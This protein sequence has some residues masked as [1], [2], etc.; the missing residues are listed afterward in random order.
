M[1]K[2]LALVASLLSC[3]R[4]LAVPTGADEPLTVT[5]VASG[6]GSVD[7]AS[8]T[9]AYGGTVSFTATAEAGKELYAQVSDVQKQGFRY[10]IEIEVYLHD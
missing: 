6:G 10:L 9:V 4:V 1:M 3:C 5:C 2:R 8:K 7:A